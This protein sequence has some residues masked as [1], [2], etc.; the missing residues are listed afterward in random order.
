[1][2][3]AGFGFT[4]PSYNTIVSWRVAQ[5]DQGKAAATMAVRCTY[6]EFFPRRRC[7]VICWE[8]HD[9]ANT[10]HHWTGHGQHWCHRWDIPIF[11]LPARCNSGWDGCNTV[12]R[13]PATLGLSP[14]CVYSMCLLFE[15]LVAMPQRICCFKRIHGYRCGGR[16]MDSAERGVRRQTDGATCLL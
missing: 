16:D 5:E 12:S 6:C 1:M 3:E 11:V 15:F 8:A 7:C 13:I 14:L 10:K 4:A 2:L 9:C